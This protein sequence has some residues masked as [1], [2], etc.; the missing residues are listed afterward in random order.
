VK[1]ELGQSPRIAATEIAVD[2]DTRS[3]TSL[4]RHSTVLMIAEKGPETIW[5]RTPVQYQYRSQVKWNAATSETEWQHLPDD[6]D[7]VY[8]RSA[9]RFSESPRPLVVS[10]SEKVAMP[11]EF[12]HYDP[13]IRYCGSL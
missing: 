3:S 6:A 12:M 9:L 8:F 2:K 1:S 7:D 5:S 11:D 10:D 4:A 13:Q